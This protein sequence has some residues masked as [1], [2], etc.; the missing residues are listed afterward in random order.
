MSP[1]LWSIFSPLYAMQKNT[2]EPQVIIYKKLHEV[3]K[4]IKR[5]AKESDV[6][7]QISSLRLKHRKD[8]FINPL[9]SPDTCV[10]IQILC[11]KFK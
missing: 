9:Q 6:Q 7:K 8:G 10:I 4:E 1:E 5:Q 3:F 11:G 2:R